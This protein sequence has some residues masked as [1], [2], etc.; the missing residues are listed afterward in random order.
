MDENIITRKITASPSKADDVFLAFCRARN[1]KHNYLINRLNN[2]MIN[3]V[4]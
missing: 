3:P 1:K 2:Q 4:S